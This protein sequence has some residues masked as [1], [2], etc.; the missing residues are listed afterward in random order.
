MDQ[1][2]HDVLGV[3]IHIPQ[4][5]YPLTN[6]SLVL[7]PSDDKP[8]S[9]I[10]AITGFLTRA[11]HPLD[12]FRVWRG[13]YKDGAGVSDLFRSAAGGRALSKDVA[14]YKLSWEARPHN[15]FLLKLHSQLSSVGCRWAITY[16]AE[17]SRAGWHWCM[18]HLPP[19]V[20]APSKYWG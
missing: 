16:F 11:A 12:I 19:S 7:P 20:E 2:I 9:G 13:T 14:S 6:C 1:P 8:S 15:D 18:S 4:G 17:S 10:C 5:V 3:N